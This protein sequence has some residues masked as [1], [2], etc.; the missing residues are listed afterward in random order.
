V[1]GAAL[2]GCSGET[3]RTESTADKVWEGTKDVGEGIKV[4]TGYVTVWSG[5]VAAAASNTVADL[6]RA[7]VG[8]PKTMKEEAPAA[9]EA[10][11][12]RVAAGPLG[13]PILASG[14]FL[15]KSMRA[16]ADS[17]PQVYVPPI[18]SQP[19]PFVPNGERALPAGSRGTPAEV[20]AGQPR[21]GETGPAYQPPPE[22]MPP[23]TPGAGQQQR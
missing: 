22:S 21:T 10:E 2:A 9:G 19:P 20:P 18:F 16:P 4:G 11:G 5:K 13:E 7:L 6:G 15:P 1:L 17:G 23:P 8:K 14:P 3:V 12:E